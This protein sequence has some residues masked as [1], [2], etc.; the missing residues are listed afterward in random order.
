VYDTNTRRPIDFGFGDNKQTQQTIDE[1]SLA[2]AA[3]GCDLLAIEMISPMGMAVG[4]EVFRTVLWIGRFYEQQVRVGGKAVLVERMAVKW[5]LCGNRTAKDA[6]IRTALID[7]YGG[8]SIAIG[9]V[10][11]PVCKQRRTQQPTCEHCRHTGWLHQP[12][13]LKGISSHVWS[14]LAVAVVASIQGGH[15]Q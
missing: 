12:G 5:T 4:I 7:R 1:C 2:T 13:P 3:N 9:G 14:A 10:K 6:N 8:E 15:E 11:C